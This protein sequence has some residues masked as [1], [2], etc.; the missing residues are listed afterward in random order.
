M[1]N[2]YL[3]ELVGKTLR[4]S[5]KN[6]FYYKGEILSVG[7]DFLVILDKVGKKVIVSLNAIETV[8]MMK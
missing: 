5:L 7:E 3:K 4:F 1:D 6:G 8:E 2:E